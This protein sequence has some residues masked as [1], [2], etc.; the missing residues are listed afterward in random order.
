MRGLV[1]RRVPQILGIYPGASLV[2][3]AYADMPVDRY[4]VSPRLV[5]LSIVLLASLIPMVVLLTGST[6]SWP[7]P[8]W[9]R[10]SLPLI[11]NRVFRLP[12]SKS[13]S[14]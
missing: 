4:L 13:D 5:D 12:V 10:I 1:H 8:E 9:L 6:A 14:S 3:V 11:G 7:E 2:V